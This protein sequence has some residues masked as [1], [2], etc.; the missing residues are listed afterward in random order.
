MF[1]IDLTD[2]AILQSGNWSDVSHSNMPPELFKHSCILDQNRSMANNEDCSLKSNVLLF[3]RDWEERKNTHPRKNSEHE[4]FYKTLRRS[5][6]ES[7]LSLC[8]S[9]IGKSHRR[10]CSESYY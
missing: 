2:A 4:I 1:N 10:A 8:G 9:D 3:F 6:S 7:S 5:I